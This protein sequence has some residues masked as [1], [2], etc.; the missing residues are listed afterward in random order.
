MSPGAE[1]R[2]RAEQHGLCI[3]DEQ[4]RNP[5][6]AAADGDGAGPRAA[7]PTLR[8]RAWPGRSSALRRADDIAAG[9]ARPLALFS[10]RSGNEAGTALLQ[11]PLRDYINA[12]LD[13]AGPPGGPRVGADAEATVSAQSCLLPQQGG[14]C[15][16]NVELMAH[17]GAQEELARLAVVASE[18]GTTAQVLTHGG[19]KQLC[20]NEAGHAR[21]FV[22]ERPH[23]AAAAGDAPLEGH[24]RGMLLVVEVPVR[25]PTRLQQ[26]TITFGTPGAMQTMQVC[27]EGPPPD[28]SVPP[29]T[30]GRAD[31][32]LDA[33]PDC[34]AVG[35]VDG[36]QP[37]LTEREGIFIDGLS[38]RTLELDVDAPI[39]CTV[40]HYQATDDVS[41]DDVALAG[42]RAT[43]EAVHAATGGGAL[44]PHPE[45][46]LA[47]AAARRAPLWF[48]R[49]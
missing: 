25:A 5:S 45:R 37:S 9:R 40:L 13:R 16:F 47:S 27:S 48:I 49:S 12:L 18:R 36:A 14:A 7:Q 22:A 1:L 44:A 28:A 33:A 15:P 4:A 20:F 24:A 31:S 43:L 21:R 41:A 26:R 32:A 30:V 42:A 34:A 8:P 10:V 2:R 39:R 3:V 6:G 23:A 46:A 17:A 19:A 38:G 29:A 35:A 11:V